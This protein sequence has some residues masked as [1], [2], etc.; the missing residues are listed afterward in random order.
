[1]IPNEIRLT[2]KGQVL[3]VSLETMYEISIE[4]MPISL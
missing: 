2:L 3:T 4:L 1:M